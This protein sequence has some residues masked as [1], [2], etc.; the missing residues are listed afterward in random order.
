MLAVPLKGLAAVACWGCDEHGP[1]TAEMVSVVVSASDTPPHSPSQSPTHSSDLAPDCHG[2]GA[3]D[4]VEVLDPAGHAS[5]CSHCGL[6]AGSAALPVM[7]RLAVAEPLSARVD[8]VIPA[9]ALGGNQ[10]R[11]ERPPRRVFA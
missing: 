5:T 8:A 1:A 3:V 6:C 10:E 4:G 11:L 9:G 2:A 7:P